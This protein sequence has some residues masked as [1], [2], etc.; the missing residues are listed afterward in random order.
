MTGKFFLWNGGSVENII[1][2]TIYTSFLFHFFIKE[3]QD[4]I[5]IT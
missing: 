5:L 1:T 3:I 2:K 4:C